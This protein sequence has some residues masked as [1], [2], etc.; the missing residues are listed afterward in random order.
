MEGIGGVCRGA[1]NPRRLGAPPPTHSPTNPRP[2]TS[3]PLAAI[4]LALTEPT[5]DVKLIV[6]ATGDTTARARIVCKYLELVYV[7]CLMGWGV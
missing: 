5:L 6:T 7:A 1:G 3:F 4:A 2:C